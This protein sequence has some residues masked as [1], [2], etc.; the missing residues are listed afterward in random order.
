MNGVRGNTTRQTVNLPVNE[1][2]RR[3]II[4]MRKQQGVRKLEAIRCLA[5]REDFV[6]WKDEHGL[7]ILHHAIINNYPD[8]CD[9]LL[10][11]GY[12]AEP[13]E[14]DV[15]LYAHLAARMGY[16][17]TLRVI[18]THRPR[19]FKRAIQPL[20]FPRLVVPIWQMIYTGGKTLM[21]GVLGNSTG[22]SSGKR[23]TVKKKEDAVFLPGPTV[24][25]IDC[26]AR[27]GLM[28]KTMGYSARPSTAATLAGGPQGALIPTTDA[29]K[30]VRQKPKLPCTKGRPLSAPLTLKIGLDKAAED[31]NRPRTFPYSEYTMLNQTPLEV[32]ANAFWPSC[33]KLLLD[34]CIKPL[35]PDLPCCAGYLTLAVLADCPVALKVLLKINRRGGSVEEERLRVDDFRQAV[36][37]CVEQQQLELLAL[38]V[39]DT[40]IDLKPMFRP[41]NGF[42]LDV[43]TDTLW[44]LPDVVSAMI[45]RDYCVETKLPSRTYPLYTC[46]ACSIRYDDLS[47]AQHYMAFEKQNMMKKE[48]KMVLNSRKA[49]SSALHCLFDTTEL[50]APKL[51]KEAV[52]DT[53]RVPCEWNNVLFVDALT[54]YLMITVQLGSVD[55]LVLNQLAR[56]G[57]HPGRKADWYMAGEPTYPLMIYFHTLFDA[58]ASKRVTDANRQFK[59]SHVVLAFVTRFMKQPDIL[60]C[61][62][63]LTSLQGSSSKPASNEQ[64][65]R[66][67]MLA[68]QELVVRSKLVPPL[69][70]LSAWR[71]WML[72]GRRMKNV[73][74]L[75]KFSTKLKNLFAFINDP[76]K[77][78]VDFLSAAYI[79]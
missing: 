17:T 43:R 25:T 59:S 29:L 75:P 62:S 58:M 67:I 6:N 53:W 21:P 10:K 35:Y 30:C 56:Y 47:L 65:R 49:Y 26:V 57:A 39:A 44:S 45:Q 38:L 14:P 51:P 74:R 76:T 41:L 1:V 33:V 50:V 31:V 18:I 52:E 68:M 7:D 40:T 8:A 9:F 60:E 54:H 5:R 64:V 16:L 66:F 69:R 28:L 27:P 34:L 46:I 55:P 79:D 13:Y 72:C 70:D 73:K 2:A 20:F 11:L 42:H 36:R 3:F 63:H 78:F 61:I 19:D 32:A 4:A 15:N 23:V 12:F 37:L 77:G 22:Y 24:K 71:V 48:F